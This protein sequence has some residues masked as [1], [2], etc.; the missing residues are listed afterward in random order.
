MHAFVLAG[1]FATRLW[2]LTESRPKPLLPV[3]GKPILTHLTEKI[4]KGI[5]I[6]VSTNAVFADAFHK[7]KLATCNPSTGSG[8]ALQ[9]S[10]L[11]EDTRADDHKLGALGAV[12][13]W[14]ADA[15]IDDDILL[16]TGDN[17]IGFSLSSFIDAYHEGTPLLAAHDIGD[18]ERAK[19]FGTVIMDIDGKSVTAFEEKPHN[20]KSTLVSTGCS[21]LP[22]SAL[23]ILT[24]YAKD[25]PDNVGG[26]FEELLRCGV[27]VQA[28]VFHEPWFDIGSFDAYLAATKA[29]VGNN[30]ITAEG[31][32]IEGG[33]M[34]GSVVMGTGCT[35]RNAT[36]ENVVLFDGC[37]IED[38]DLSD[39]ICDDNCLIRGIDLRGKMLR[40][41]TKL[42]QRS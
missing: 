10:V 28:F 6:T 34:R 33:S 39:C 11:I 25:H 20:P 2:P 21:I 5:P 26:I 4:P 3:A 29:I 40:K 13:Q 38:C 9:L 32:H 7:W 15:K 23:S 16:L 14:I 30:V 41:N 12:A 42:V 37:I 35:V 18:L 31:S 17:Y 1:G 36:L 8:Q 24:A 19:Q 27:P 22:R